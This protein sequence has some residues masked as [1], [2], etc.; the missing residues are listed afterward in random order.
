MKKIL[1]LTVVLLLSVFFSS[2]KKKAGHTVFETES[3]FI[4][5]AC[6][7]ANGRV[8]VCTDNKSIKAFSVEDGSLL[9]SFGGGHK[10]DVLCVDLSPD[11]TLLVSGGRDSVVAFYDFITSEVLHRLK[12]SNGVITDVRFSP[13]N[14]LV[15]IGSSGSTA[16]LYSIAEKK[17][18]YEISDFKKDITSVDFDSYGNRMVVASADKSIRVYN[19][20]TFDTEM[21]LKGHRSWIRSVSFYNDGN[22]LISCSDDRRIVFWNIANPKKIR[23]AKITTFKGWNLSIDAGNEQENKSY[24]YVYGTKNG[25]IQFN[26]AF[27]NYYA[28]LSSPVVKVILAPDQGSTIRIIAATLGDGLLLLDGKSMKFSSKIMK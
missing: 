4:H 17:F 12:I 7:S 1:Y 28:R 11:S 21:V 26:Y 20:R 24:H 3:R 5:D 25:F 27:G 9:A 16:Y 13:D 8:V 22:S 15:L 23:S 18:V 14:R 10:D 6:L 2:A 19:A